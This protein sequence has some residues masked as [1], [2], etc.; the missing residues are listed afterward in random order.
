MAWAP[1][2]MRCRQAGLMRVPLESATCPVL[3][4]HSN[5]FPTPATHTK[6]PPAL[7]AAAISWSPAAHPPPT[8]GLLEGAAAALAHLAGEVEEGIAGLELGLTAAEQRIKGRLAGTLQSAIR[9]EI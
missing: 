2:W 3:L 4:W 7:L 5:C 8:Q 9:S 6:L 1:G